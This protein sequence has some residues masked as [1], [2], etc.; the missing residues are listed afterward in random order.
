[1]AKK[2]GAKTEVD[3]RSLE[4]NWPRIS[5]AYTD[6]LKG[7]PTP[8]NYVRFTFGDHHHHH[9]LG[10]FKGKLVLAKYSRERAPE[11]ACPDTTEQ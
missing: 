5:E 7:T 2:G 10:W 11:E 4:P 6:Q 8:Q 3:R 9:A 1:M